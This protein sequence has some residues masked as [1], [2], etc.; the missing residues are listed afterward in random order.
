MLS[1]QPSYSARGLAPSSR[2]K[3]LDGAADE[4]GGGFFLTQMLAT[5]KEGHLSPPPKQPPPPAVR[6]GG[7]GPLTEKA[8]LDR[9]FKKKVGDSMR[10]Y[11]QS[12]QHGS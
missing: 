4:D 2:P 9:Q 8:V 11:E 7:R 10:N 5:R 1:Q 6:G 3:Q 12:P